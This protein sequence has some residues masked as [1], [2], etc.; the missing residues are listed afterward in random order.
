MPTVLLIALDPKSVDF[1]DPGLPPGLNADM[2]QG[3]LKLAHEEMLGRGWQAE[4]CY[5][6]Q[7]ANAGVVLDRQLASKAYDCVV[8]GAGIRQMPSHLA[9]FET[10]TNAV[11]RG[12]PRASIAFN[13]GPGDTADAAARWLGCSG[14]N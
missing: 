11:H 5:I 3:A 9:L 6:Q 13:T 2:M 7:D 1:S 10:V 4:V 8:I 14:G 12:A